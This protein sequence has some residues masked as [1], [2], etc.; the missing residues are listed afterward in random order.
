VPA[1]GGFYLNAKGELVVQL[2]D[3]SRGEAMRAALVPFLQQLA[4][5]RNNPGARLPKIVF[6]KAEYS[7]AQLSDWRE[8]IGPVFELEGVVLLDL[9]EQRNRLTVGLKDESGRAEA[10]AKVREL[11]VP[12]EVVRIAIYG[13]P[14]P[15]TGNANAAASVTSA[16]CSWLRDVCRPLV[17]GFEISFVQDGK[18][19]ICTLGFP[20]LRDGW[21]LGFV[22][23]SHCSDDEWNLDY[24]P[25]YQPLYGSQ[26]GAEAVDPPGWGA[27][28]GCEVFYK[29]RHSDSNFVRTNAGVAVDV[30][31]IGRTT[32]VNNRDLTVDA[33]QPRFTITSTSSVYGGETIYMMGRTTGW[34]QGSI[35]HTCSNFKYTW[36]GRWHKVLCSDV[37][38]ANIKGGDSGGPVFLWNGTSDRITLVGINFARN[39]YT[40]DHSFFSSLKQIRQEQGMQNLEVRAPEF[41]GSTGGGGGGGGCGGTSDTMI[42]EPC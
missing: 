42:I 37:H 36:E 22:T 30:G 19:G 7:F 13:E 3:L 2:T 1:F 25:Y 4:A 23:A 31:Y 29:C 18:L 26:V 21:D 32:G 20:A 10:E 27:G 12:R 14:K 41:R 17:G 35:T 8:Q 34:L 15:L 6:Q 40:T 9:D 38:N 24:T 39:G 33:A 28:N 11:G 16:G 5:E